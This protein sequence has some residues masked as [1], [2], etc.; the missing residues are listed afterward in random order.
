MIKSISVGPGL[1]V[2]NP[3]TPYISPSGGELV[4]S[5]KYNTTTQNVEVYNGSSW[6]PLTNS[7][8][9]EMDS[10]IKTAIDWARKKMDEERRIDELCEKFPGLRKAKDNYEVVLNLVKDEV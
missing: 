5:V 1:T 2:S 10:H 6:V 4:G 7:V 8:H 3:A 9:I